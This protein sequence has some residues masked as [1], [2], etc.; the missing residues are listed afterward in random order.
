MTE[1]G[2]G[3]LGR[4]L[5]RILVMLPFAIKHPGVTIDELSQR[6]GVSRAELLEDLNLVFLCGLPG[7]DPGDLIDVSIDDERVYVSMAD[8]FAAP[9]RLTPSEGLMLYAG[10]LAL[11]KLPEMSEADALNS[12]LEKLAEVIGIEDRKALEVRVEGGWDEHLRRID[13]ALREERRLRI[14]YLSA[15]SGELSTREI[16]PW[17]IVAARGRWYLIAFDRT[18]D[19]ERMFRLDRMRD[20]VVT[21]EPAEVP[22]DFDPS[23]YKAAF[24]DRADAPSMTI[25]V[26]PEV[27]TWFLDYYPTRSHQPLDDGWMRVEMAYTGRRWAALLIVRLGAAVRSVTPPEVS[28]DAADIAKDILALYA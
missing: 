22:E 7:Y 21:E 20:V 3:R 23:R 9:L 5:N 25:E 11:S 1:G 14:E 4:R 8:Y 28:A 10:A 17:G 27:A 24:V 16:D 13:E 26:S 6:F 12:A 19:D 15:S 2:G 18:V